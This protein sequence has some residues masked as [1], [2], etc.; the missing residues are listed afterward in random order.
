ML[1]GWDGG[2]MGSTMERRMWRC[3]R[4]VQMA[5]GV[6]QMCKLRRCS[7]G[8]DGVVVWESITWFIV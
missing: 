7:G 5:E 2:W 8:C 3:E 6:V 1:V 4:V